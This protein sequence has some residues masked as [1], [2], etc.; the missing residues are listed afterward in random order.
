MHKE[1]LKRITGAY[2]G[3]EKPTAGKDEESLPLDPAHQRSVLQIRLNLGLLVPGYSLPSRL[4]FQPCLKANP[5]DDTAVEAL[6]ACL[7]ERTADGRQRGD[8]NVIGS[9]VMPAFI[10]SAE[11]CRAIYGV[12]H[13]YREWRQRWFILDRYASEQGRKTHVQA[14]LE[15]P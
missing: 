10:R 7:A 6:S 4:D 12:D 9:A 11:A 5:L 15:V 2:Q 3:I 1:L 13:G 14:A 8:A